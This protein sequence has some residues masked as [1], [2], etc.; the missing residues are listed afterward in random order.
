VKIDV[1]RHLGLIQREV[2]V[3]DREGKPAQVLTASRT[4]ETE[5]DDV[6][7][8]ITNPER[9]ARW[10]SPVSGELREGGRFQIEGNAGGKI[11]RCDPPKS[12]ALTW[13]Y[14][15]DVS[16]VGVVLTEVQPGHTRL[17][18]E[19]AAHTPEDFWER[20]GAGA[21]GV[22]WDLAILGLAEHLAGAADIDP[23]QAE[24]WPATPDGNKWVAHCSEGWGAA[25]VAAGAPKTA[26]DAAVARTFAF[27]TGQA[28]P[29]DSTS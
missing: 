23:K 20:Y 24:Q 2:A 22:G 3:R 11:V 21:T 8:A 14:G 29:V 17:V 16:W 9:I 10:F 7:D 26:S 6:W 13:E 4:Y 5:I 15:G 12:V 27:Y 18:L 19:H 25:Q 1:T 28:E